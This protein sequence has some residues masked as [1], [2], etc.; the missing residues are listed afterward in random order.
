MRI[1]LNGR[2]VDVDGGATVADAVTASGARERHGVAVAVEG[3]VVPRSEWDTTP[4]REGQ[5][6]EVL[7]AV[8]GG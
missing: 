7:H 3:E 6:I 1:E 5:Q 8:Q 4:L 2:P